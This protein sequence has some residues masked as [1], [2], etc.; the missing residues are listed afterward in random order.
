M[1]KNTKEERNAQLRRRLKP[2]VTGPYKCKKE[3][4]YAQLRR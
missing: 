3:E 4:R 2:A 1:S